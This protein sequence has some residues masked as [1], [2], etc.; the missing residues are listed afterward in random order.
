MHTEAAGSIQSSAA[1]FAL[2]VLCLLVIDQDLEV[3]KVALAVV[4]PRSC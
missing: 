2:E 3:I 1:S 4:A